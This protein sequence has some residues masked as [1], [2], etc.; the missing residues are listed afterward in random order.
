MKKSIL[1]SIMLCIFMFT[2]IFVIP[3]TGDQGQVYGATVGKTKTAKQEVR[4]VWIGYIDYKALGLYNRSKKDFTANAG[5]FF[6]KAKANNINTA[7]FHVRAF[8]DATYKSK[9]FKMSRF[10]WDK[11]SKIPYDPLKIIISQAHKNGIKLH[12]WMN[13][14]RNHKSGQTILNPA[15]ASSTNEI[16]RCVKEVIRGYD[17]DGIHFD[18]YFYPEHGYSSVRKSTRRANVNK[19]IRAVY[20][21]V[22]SLD[23]SVKF[24]ISPAANVDFCYDIGADIKTWM[25]KPGYVDYIAPQIYW[26]DNHSAKWRKRMYTDTLRE[27]KSLNKKDKE[28]YVGLAGYRAGTHQRE[29]RG[30][31]A[32]STNLRTQ[33]S[34]LRSYGSEGYILFSAKDLLRRSAKKEFTNFNR[35]VKGNP[36]KVSLKAKGV[37]YKTI[38]L[39]WEEVSSASGYAVYRAS[40]KTGKYVKV[41]T[42][43]LRSK[44]S[45]N[46][47]GRIPGHTYYYK[48]RS[49]KNLAETKVYGAYSKV[50]KK[51]AIPATSKI[52]ADTGKNYVALT[53]NKVPRVDGYE[54]YR[55]VTKAGKYE[56]IKV[57]SQKSKPKY[58]DKKIKKGRKNYYKL[59]GFKKIKGK[60]L[61]SNY[62]NIVGKTV[63]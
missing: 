27:W 6:K 33:L 11:K 58:T 4:G 62:T 30:W 16:L 8:R 32:R 10:M 17:I 63:K 23:K 31:A 60:R 43:S 41:K 49:T 39:R 37:D 19:M 20:K 55:K 24:G 21:T 61:Y 15:K 46:N 42:L 28:L 2:S 22:K 52:K 13:P 56:K 54:L 36:G 3:L 47:T 53:W 44:T 57:I 18:D 40:E 51:T 38:G 7:Y 34:L 35:A 12:A 26:T 25:N 48:V 1:V 9:Y 50:V 14:Y 45:Y 59:R 29:D 5:K